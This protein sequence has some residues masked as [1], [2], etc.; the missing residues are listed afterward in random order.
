[1][2][3]TRKPWGPNAVVIPDAA[4]DERIREA[5]KG[6]KSMVTVAFGDTLI[7]LS[8]DGET[9]D[10]DGYV[11]KIT[12]RI[13]IDAA[14]S[15]PLDPTTPAV[16]TE[17]QGGFDIA[18]RMLAQAVLALD[19][20]E[21]VKADAGYTDY[22]RGDVAQR[23]FALASRLRDAEA[24]AT[25]LEGQKSA[26]IQFN[27]EVAADRAHLTKEL[28]GA[29]EDVVEWKGHALRDAEKWRDA[30]QRILMITGQLQFSREKVSTLTE[31][32]KALRGK[33]EALPAHEHDADGDELA[34]PLIGLYAVLALLAEEPAS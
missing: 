25:E 16:P 28:E 5:A 15:V 1:M 17:E 20:A 23:Q 9:G 19:S 8:R 30:K 26:L 14:L 6:L 4:V 32:R 13:A 34:D 27:G 18:L 24:R 10:V 31:E 22:L 29:K 2:R 3:I 21:R 12:Y 7:V 33:I 11:A